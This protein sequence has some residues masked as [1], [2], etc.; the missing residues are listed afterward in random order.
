MLYLVDQL[1][2]TTCISTS[3]GTELYYDGGGHCTSGAGLGSCNAAGG[4][5]RVDRDGYFYVV[6]FCV[7]VGAA[8]A[9]LLKKYYV[10]LQNAPDGAWKARTISASPA[11]KQAID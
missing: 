4:T 9:A 11:P 2:Q 1:T 5:C 10:P 3:S 6:G 8:L 7:I